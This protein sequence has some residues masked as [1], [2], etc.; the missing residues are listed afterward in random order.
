MPL[1]PRAPTLG[2]IACVLASLLLP[3]P[4]TAQTPPTAQETAAYTGLHAAA[5]K[6]DVGEIARLA[7][8]GANLEARD[9]HGRTPLVVAAFRRDVATARALIAAGAD[10]NALESQ[11]YDVITIAAVLDD[12]EMLKLAIASGGNTRAITSPY[13][14]TALIAAAHLGHAEVV[15]ALIAGKAPLDHVNNLGWT[16][17]I[18]AIVL[19][20]GGPRHQATV[21]ALIKGGADLNLADGKGVSPLSLARARGYGR[22][23]EMLAQAGAKP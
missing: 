6:G 15:A 13:K 21:A 3:A 4:T 23:A 5:A 22:I 10:L 17:L 18:E 12:L 9:G 11:A 14:G 2:L 8:A 1:S 20:D 16:A 19:G 7:K